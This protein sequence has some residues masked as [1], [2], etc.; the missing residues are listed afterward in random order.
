MIWY[1]TKLIWNWHNATYCNLP[2]HFFDWNIEQIE[3]DVTND[4]IT[5]SVNILFTILKKVQ[6][7]PQKGSFEGSP[8]KSV[9]NIIGFS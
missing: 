6:W 1:V 3:I 5:V 7:G 8:P 2:K 9:L 4:G